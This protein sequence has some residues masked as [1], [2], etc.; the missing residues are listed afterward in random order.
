MIVEGTPLLYSGGFT[1]LRRVFLL[2]SREATLDTG[3]RA[4]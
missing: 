4:Q 1:L 2:F 3:S